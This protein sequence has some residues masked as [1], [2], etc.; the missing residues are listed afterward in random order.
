M[1]ASS[2]DIIVKEEEEQD[3]TLDYSEDSLRQKTTVTAIG[4]V[5]FSQFMKDILP[6]WQL[7]KTVLD[8]FVKFCVL[9]DMKFIFRIMFSL[10]IFFTYRVSLFRFLLGV[11]YDN[12]NHF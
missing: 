8:K 4:K 9:V 1:A 2:R 10:H 5:S 11:N 7:P 3:D 6:G 12:C